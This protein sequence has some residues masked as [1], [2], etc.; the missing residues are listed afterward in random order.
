MV[1]NE[2]RAPERTEGGHHMLARIIRFSSTAPRRVLAAVALVMVAIGVFGIPVAK[3]LS[4]SG[5]ADPTSE[6]ASATEVLAD[7][8]G[9]V[10][11][12]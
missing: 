12:Q 8:L 1:M 6:S 9:Q 5:M 2:V 4:A 3:H 7:N 11:I 10:D